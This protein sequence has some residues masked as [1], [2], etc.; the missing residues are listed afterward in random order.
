MVKHAFSAMI[1]AVFLAA[2]IASVALANPALPGAQPVGAT[3]IVRGLVSGS[4]G[5]PVANATVRLFAPDSSRSTMTDASGKYQFSGV[6]IG[7]YYVA[8]S[9]DGYRSQSSDTIYVTEVS[10]IDVNVTLLRTS[11]PATLGTVTVRSQ[12]GIQT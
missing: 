5:A 6:G 10:T 11:G 9:K 4:D 3:S 12:R 1:L 8:V 7:S 2:S